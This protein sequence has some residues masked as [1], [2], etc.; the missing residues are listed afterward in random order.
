MNIGIDIDG[1]ITNVDFLSILGKNTPVLDRE[2]KNLKT[3]NRALRKLLYKGIAFYSKHSKLRPDAS[4]YI[5][6]LKAEGNR[7]IIIT[8]RKFASEDSKEGESIR[9]L[10]ELFLLE[11][12][13]PYDKIIF[14]T[15]DKLEDCTT[16][17][18]TI[19]LEDSPKNTASIS[20][21]V[22]VILMDTPYNQNTAGDNVFRVNSWEEAYVLL[23]A[24]GKRKAKN[25][26]KN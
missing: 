12:D 14:S 7:I 20:Q 19:M 13:I 11:N 6:L 25:Y 15:G 2:S 23:S 4:K 8:K 26:E 17:D 22:P 18:I 9:A 1:V 21:R 3:N 10:V 16:E 5:K 24:L